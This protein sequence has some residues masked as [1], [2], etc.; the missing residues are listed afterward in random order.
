LTPDEARS[1]AEQMERDRA[2]RVAAEAAELDDP[3]ELADRRAARK[4]E[5]GRLIAERVRRRL[6]GQ[7]PRPRRDLR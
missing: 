5:R 2:T 6:A 4:A 1:M 3:D 7:N